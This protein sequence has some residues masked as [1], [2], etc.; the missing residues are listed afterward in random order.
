V[1]LGA[2]GIEEFAARLWQITGK[3][4]TNDSENQGELKGPF[5]AE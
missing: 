1:T 5:H 2:V 3:N 4:G